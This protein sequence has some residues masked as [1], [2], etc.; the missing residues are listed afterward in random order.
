MA[1][2]NIGATLRKV[3]LSPIL[4]LA[5]LGPWRAV[6]VLFISTSPQ[7]MDAMIGEFPQGFKSEK[8]CQD[9]NSRSDP[10]IHKVILVQK[11]VV[12][13]ELICIEKPEGRGI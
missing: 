10:G 13:Y 6:L 9:F 11:Q 5:L 7:T 2:L 12:G 3:R 8:A 1:T 4:A